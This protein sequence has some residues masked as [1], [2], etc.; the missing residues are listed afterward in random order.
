VANRWFGFIAIGVWAVSS[1]VGCQASVNARVKAS[2]SAADPFA[3]LDD[4]E[5]TQPTQKATASM[6]PPEER[7]ARA[8]APAL[9]GAR[10]D[11][12]LKAGQAAACSCLAVVVGDATDP[13]FVW[14]SAI[15]ETESDEQLVVAFSTQ[16]QA[17][18]G[19]VAMN[20]AYRGY[21]KS[22]DDVIV[23]LEEAKDGRP[24]LTGAIVPRPAAGG[25]LL[26]QPSGADL[27]FGKG[28]AGAAECE[29]TALPP[30]LTLV[31]ATLSEEPPQPEAGLPD[32]KPD[33]GPNLTGDLADDSDAEDEPSPED[34]DNYGAAPRSERD[35]FYFALLAG[36]GYAMMDFTVAPTLPEGQ[37]TGIPVLFDVL[38]GGSP[39]PDLAVGAI[40]G[41]GTARNPAMTV[42]AP[43]GTTL[44]QELS[45]PGFSVDGDTVTFTDLNLNLLRVGAFADYY[46]SRDSNL[47]SLLEVGYTSVFFSGQGSSSDDLS[48]LS[49]GA[50]L[51]Y[52]TWLSEHWSLGL[53]ARFSYVPVSAKNTDFK[54]TLLLPALVLNL[55]FH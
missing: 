27:P 24:A 11:L 12:Y 22:G 15:P 45:A 17:C 41:G 9:F 42:N 38:I 46:F 6:A 40:L 51:G 35:S 50:G 44:E 20:A 5:P 1:G 47:H 49:L 19:G 55:T 3:E 25:R 26:I 32:Q 54:S 31:T 8:S 34:L 36:A 18:A 52:D 29:L 23:Q 53:L 13:R 2:D 21:V 14:E 33:L 7:S 10:H 16:G 28:L 48:G 4:T 30:V 39:L 37:L 43:P